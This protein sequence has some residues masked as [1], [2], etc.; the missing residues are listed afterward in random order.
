MGKDC[1][2]AARQCNHQETLHP[3]S[4]LYSAG[5]KEHHT[6]QA[7]IIAVR[8]RTLGR[9]PSAYGSSHALMIP[10]PPLWMKSSWYLRCAHRGQTVDSSVVRQASCN[11]VTPTWSHRHPALGPHTSSRH[12]ASLMLPVAA[13][14]ICLPG[15]DTT[16]QPYMVSLLSC[17]ES[18]KA[19][20]CTRAPEPGNPPPRP[21]S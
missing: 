11:T 17:P 4:G 10:R 13:T 6:L 2:A 20:V 5:S 18:M 21:I 1:R 8:M 19:P 9:L 12:Q 14:S 3:R 7:L 16:K 15:S